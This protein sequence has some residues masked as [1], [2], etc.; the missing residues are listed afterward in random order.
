MRTAAWILL[1][2]L[3]AAVG[4]SDDATDSGAEPR[5]SSTA[6]QILS[7]ASPTKDE[8]PSVLRARDGSMFIAWFSD[9]DGAG[10]IYVV[11]SESQTNWSNPVRVTLDP[12]GDFYPT[13]VQDDGGYTFSTWFRWYDF[14]RGHIALHLAGR[15]P[16]NVADEES[17]TT[18]PDID[19]WAHARLRER[20]HHVHLFCQRIARH[21]QPDE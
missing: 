16:L 13:L 4:C 1:F 10:D 15:N 19:D 12:G 7:T 3:G 20:W 17:V 6:S 9:R 14:F 18:D 8:D 5:Y 2:G 21:R 11:R